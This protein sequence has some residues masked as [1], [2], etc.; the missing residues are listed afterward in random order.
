MEIQD[1]TILK[2]LTVGLLLCTVFGVLDVFLMVFGAVCF[3][4][5]M[6]GGLLSAKQQKAK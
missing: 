6:F 4:G 3:V 5:L 2:L 1:Q